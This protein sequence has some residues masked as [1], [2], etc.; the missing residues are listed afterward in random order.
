MEKLEKEDKWVEVE[1]Q[2]WSCAVVGVVARPR[3]RHDL[4]LACAH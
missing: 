1:V 2:V 4:Q 3:P